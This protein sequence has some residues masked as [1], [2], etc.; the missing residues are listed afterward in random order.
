ML[1]ACGACCEGCSYAAAECGGTCEE[2]RGRVFWARYIGA[3]VCPIY[4]C[5]QDNGHQ[6]CGDCAKL[7]CEIWFNVKDPN[8]SEEEGQKSVA[9][10]VAKLK[11]A[12]G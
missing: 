2:L 4:Q 8:V 11:A 1:C 3:E 9:D 6:N 7:P 12:R 10:R 5:V